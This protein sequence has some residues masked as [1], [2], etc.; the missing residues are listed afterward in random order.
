[1][2]DIVAEFL[3]AR[4]DPSLLQ[5]WSNTVLGEPFEPPQEAIESSSLLRRGENY[6]PQSI[7]NEVQLLVAGVDVQGDRLEV[8]IVGYAAFEETWAVLY[9]V[10]PGDPAQE[11]VWQLLDHVLSECY[12]TDTGREL[13]VRVTAVDTGGHHQHNVLT[14]CTARRRNN[15]FAIKGVAGPRPIWPHRVSRTKNNA[16]IWMVGV[17]TAK[18]TLYGR[19]RIANPGPGYMHFPVGGAFDAAYFSQ[20]TAEVVRLRYQQGRP[21][22]VW[23]L[24]SGKRNEA[25]DTAAYALAARTA[26]KIAVITPQ[27]EL[28][29]SPPSPEDDVPRA[30]MPR[31]S[32]EE[33]ESED[34]PDPNTVHQAYAQSRRQP[35]RPSG[36]IHEGGRPHGRWFDR[37]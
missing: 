36:W 2:T 16:Q 37:E 23:I 27:T 21:Y 9:S 17:D 7:P 15:V 34:H 13:R 32:F 14:Y 33:M 8:Q 35:I 5:V 26:T 20:L 29:L 24:P 31:P 19:L 30:P 11:Q 18:D 12:H 28:G 25:L 22:R 4:K 3:A 1:L 6:S 10:L